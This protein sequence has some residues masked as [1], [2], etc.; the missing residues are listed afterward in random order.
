MPLLNL[1]AVVTKAAQL[2]AH[3]ARDNAYDR[4]VMLDGKVVIGDP[5]ERFLISSKYL[6]TSGTQALSDAVHKADATSQH[7]RSL[8]GRPR[9]RLS[10]VG[11]AYLGNSGSEAVRGVGERVGEVGLFRGSRLERGAKR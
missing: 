8:R 7:L 11:R 3:K 5:D 6:I 1:A 4:N 2:A 9:S 10:G